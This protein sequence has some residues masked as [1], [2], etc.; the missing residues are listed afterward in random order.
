M[1][2]YNI[3]E[4]LPQQPPFL[5]V[6]RLCHCDPVVTRTELRVREGNLF[7]ENGILREP[8]VVEN[9]AQTCAARIG[10]V[11]KMNDAEVRIGFIG[12]LKS[13]TIGELPKVDEVL[14][15][16]IEVQSEVMSL[17]LVKATVMCSG[18]L[19]AQC[20]MKIAVSE[21]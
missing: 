3:E 17:T 13:L 16:Q 2:E 8:G 14:E 6:D 9:I 7:C 12:A 21:N 11:N 1:E 10:Y 15:T 18:R 5:M 19:V 4:L 20:D